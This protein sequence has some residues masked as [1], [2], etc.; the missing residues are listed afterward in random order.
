VSV[1]VEVKVLEDRATLAVQRMEASANP[2]R[3]KLR[4][5]PA[6][7]QLTRGWLRGL[8]SN[9]RNWPTT[10]F[11]QRA[12]RAT[13]WAATQEGVTISVNQIGVRQRYHGG[14]ISAVK[15]KALAIP[16][17][18]VSYGHVPSD[19]PGLFLLKTKTGAFLVQS[20]LGAN[21]KGKLVQVKRAGGN[22]GRK[23]ASLNFLFALKKSVK[24]APNEGVLPPDDAYY[25]TAHQAIKE[26][27]Q[28]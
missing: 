16:I 21:A 26:A 1:A 13:T 17:S 19:F 9:K 23:T 2:D 3:L 7:A 6:C 14:T 27:I 22:A 18:P 15:A 28:T 10:N 20:G 24:Q 8:P 5:G 25:V 11:W 12:S 4:V